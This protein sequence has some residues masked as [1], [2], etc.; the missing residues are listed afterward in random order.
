MPTDTIDD[1]Y[2]DTA[3]WRATS[4]RRVV[5][6]VHAWG[7]LRDIRDWDGFARLWHD[8]GWMTATWWQGP[9]RDF[10]EV[11]RQSFERG[12]RIS[13]F[14]GNSVVDVVR[15]RA[16]AQTR[17][18]ISQRAEVDGVVCDVTCHG[19]FYDLFAHR[20]DRWGVVERRH[21]YERDR[22]DPVDPTARPELDRSLLERFPVGYRH[23]AYLQ[24]RI[25]YEVDPDLPGIDGAALEALYER[26]AQW[27]R[28]G[29][30]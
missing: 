16:V 17:M 7:L 21:V 2:F 1:R 6:L 22:I 29:N 25:G 14:L 11:S 19:R 10:I 3:E 18:T 24:T 23:L 8:D 12:V 13:H 30:G 28:A 15:R 27:L 9:Y 26:G 5:E 20:D 4:A